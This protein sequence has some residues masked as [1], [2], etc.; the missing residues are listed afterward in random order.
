MPKALLG[1]SHAVRARPGLFA[2]VAFAVVALDLLLPIAVLSLARK[3]WDYAAFNAWL[4]NLPAYLVSDAPLAH[5]RRLLGKKILEEKSATFV[6][7]TL[8]A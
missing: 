4:P 7:E 8:H 6:K 5:F 3:P 2:G 1:I